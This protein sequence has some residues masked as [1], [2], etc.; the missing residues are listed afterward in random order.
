M[1]FI[2]TYSCIGLIL[3][4]P[5]GHPSLFILLPCLPMNYL[6]SFAIALYGFEFTLCSCSNYTVISFIIHVKIVIFK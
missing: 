3:M 4:G 1:F 2:I 6:G 5:I